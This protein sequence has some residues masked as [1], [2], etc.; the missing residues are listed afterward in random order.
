MAESRA[1]SRIHVLSVSAQPCPGFRDCAE[2]PR[3]WVVRKGAGTGGAQVKVE[4]V[5]RRGFAKG[6]RRLGDTQSP[7]LR[8]A[9]AAAG[10]GCRAAPLL[11]GSVEGSRGVSAVSARGFVSHMDIG[12]AQLAA[13]GV[14]GRELVCDG[15]AAFARKRRASP[16][17][18]TL[19]AS[20]VATGAHKIWDIGAP[21]SARRSLKRFEGGV[22]LV[23]QASG[24]C[25]KS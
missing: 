23:G 10:A 21:A 12:A 20:F 24:Y 3:H 22:A 5:R 4:G 11:Q 19:H 18:R 1:A 15:R 17:S 25:P 14:S 16:F 9:G 13:P 8:S 2:G 6:P 7:R